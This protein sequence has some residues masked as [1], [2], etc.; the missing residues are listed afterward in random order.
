MSEHNVCGAEF[1]LHID[2][3]PLAFCLGKPGH[4]GKHWCRMFFEWVPD[5]TPIQEG[6]EFLSIRYHAGTVRQRELRASL[7]PVAE[8]PEAETGAADA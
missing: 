8:E 5:G 6:V 3:N 7:E 4:R 1:F 2:G